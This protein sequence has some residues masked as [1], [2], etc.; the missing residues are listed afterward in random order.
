MG[1]VTSIEWTDATWNPWQGCLKVSPGCK[2]CYMY[3]DMPRYGRDPR[4]VVRSKTTFT[5]PLKWARQ[6]KEGIK[7]FT[8]SWSDWFIDQADEWRD[9]AWNVV[10]QTPQFAYQILTK[11]PE[12]ILKRL[13]PDWGEGWPNVWL[14]VSVES[15]SYLSRLRE[16]ER[17]PASVRF[18]SY[19][20]ALEYVHF[21]PYLENKKIHWLISGGESGTEPRPAELDWFRMVRDSCQEHGIAYFHKQH[22][23]NKKADGVWGGRELDGRTWDE[24]PHV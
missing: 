20:P 12:N 16:L 17:I 11:R 1:E 2:Q 21:A 22:G 9:E 14:G 24:F 15:P 19:E 10:R 3:R 8:C 18:I 7:I 5:A 13:P 23:G 6:G 4:V